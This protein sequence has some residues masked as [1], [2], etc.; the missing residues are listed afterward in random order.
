[1]SLQS[2]GR[3]RVTVTDELKALGWKE[4]WRVKEAVDGDEEHLEADSSSVSQH[5][6]NWTA[7]TSWIKIIN[8]N[9][10]DGR[11]KVRNLVDARGGSLKGVGMNDEGWDSEN[12]KCPNNWQA[13]Q[14]RTWTNLNQWVGI[15]NGVLVE[16][17]QENKLPVVKS[18][19]PYQKRP[20][21]S[22][23]NHHEARQC[24]LREEQEGEATFLKGARHRYKALSL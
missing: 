15:W 8:A 12:W 4:Y 3:K 16:E 2:G 14:A 21:N 19:D 9:Q 11:S 6:P 20:K 13:G 18:K 10:V 23:S 5:A 1:M 22:Q 17:I 7:V 24:L